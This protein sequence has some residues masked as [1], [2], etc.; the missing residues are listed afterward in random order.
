MPEF[1]EIREA[2]PYNIPRQ[3]AATK[4]MTKCT[5]CLDRV[6][7]GLKPACV[8][9]CPTGAMNFGDREEMLALA[10]KRL[11]E[12][13]KKYPEATLGDADMVR[14]IYLYQMP[15][16]SYHDFAVASAT[17]PQ[18]HEPQGH[19]RQA[20]RP[21]IQKQGLDRKQPPPLAGREGN[22]PAFLHSVLVRPADLLRPRRH[23][24]FRLR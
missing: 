6:Q 24:R 2:C 15:P 7:N 9:S 20:L 22:F 5:M 23:F 1:D 11:A 10:E 14:V 8:Q 16:K 12:V 3:D 18:P 17:L 19:V 13:Q 21:C 4:V